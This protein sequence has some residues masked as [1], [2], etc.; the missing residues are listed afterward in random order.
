MQSSRWLLGL[1][2]SLIAF[3]VVLMI[4]ELAERVKAPL[5]RLGRF[6]PKT[7]G[8]GFWSGIGVGA[9]LGFVCAPCAGPLL[10]ADPKPDFSFA[11]VTDTHLGKPGADYVK[12]MGDAVAEINASGGIRSMGGAKLKLLEY[13]TGDSA[14]KAKDAAQRLLA[15]EP[16]VVGGFGCWLSTFTLAVTEVTERPT[17]GRAAVHRDE[18]PVLPLLD[19]RDQ[20]ALHGLLHKL[21]DVGIP[22][23]SLTQ[24]PPDAPA[25]TVAPPAPRTRR[26]LT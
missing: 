11:L 14:E 4:P 3:G 12:R 8:D 26:K 10:A 18:L 21:R 20:A 2:L 24:L 23:I 7:R 6:G 13:D 9:A 17:S 5:S 1:A 25:S 19:L 22:L 16:D 15:Q